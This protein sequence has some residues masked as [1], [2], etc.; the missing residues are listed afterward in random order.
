MD[1][2]QKFDFDGKAIEF[3]LSK[4]IMVNATEMGKVFGTDVG[5]FLRTKETKAFI[6][7]CLNTANMQYLNI[8]KEEDLFV[9]N[10]KSG[11][12]MHRILALKFA[13]W[14][15][16]RFELWVYATIDKLM[17]GHFNI[18]QR[19]GLLKEKTDAAKELEELTKKLNDTAD[20]KRLQELQYLVETKDKQLKSLT[21]QAINSQLALFQ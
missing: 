8:E 19:N 3:D 18:E 17:F 16:P 11:T 20:F 9:S 6:S 15:N 21:K 10:Q 1:K 12:F 13:S 4:N 2:I 14:L 7:E 5:Q